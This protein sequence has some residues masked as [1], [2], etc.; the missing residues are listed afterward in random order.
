MYHLIKCVCKEDG[1]ITYLGGATG[2][3]TVAEAIAL[4]QLS[5]EHLYVEPDILIHIVN[6]ENGLPDYVAS[7][8]DGKL[9]NNLDNLPL[10]NDCP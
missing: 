10:C 2:G 6:G 5:Y 3:W 8:K 9:T 4:L 7:M 1:K